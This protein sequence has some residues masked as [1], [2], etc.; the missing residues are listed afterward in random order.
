MGSGSIAQPVGHLTASRGH[1][2]ES[3][4]GPITF[5]EIDHG[6]I[7]RVILPLPLIQEGH[8]SVTGESICTSTGEPIESYKPAQGKCE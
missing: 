8:L 2:F 4:P 3:Q 7:S 5:V 6:S 1:K